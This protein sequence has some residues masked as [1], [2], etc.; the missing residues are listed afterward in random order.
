MPMPAPMTLLDTSR[1]VRRTNRQT[2]GM[3]IWEAYSL[4]NADGVTEWH[5]HRGEEPGT[6]WHLTHLP[7]GRM[8]NYAATSLPSARR[9]TE[10]GAALA[11]LNARAARRVNAGLVSA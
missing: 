11:E 10:S 3:Q 2:G 8:L 7:T 4:A 5:Y 1:T 6:H 9:F